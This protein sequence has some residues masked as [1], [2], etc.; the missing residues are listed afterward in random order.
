MICNIAEAAL[1]RDAVCT[2]TAAHTAPG[3]WFLCSLTILTFILDE[4]TPVSILGA[5][6]ELSDR[7]LLAVVGASGADGIVLLPTGSLVDGVICGIFHKLYL[8]FYYI[9]HSGEAAYPKRNASAFLTS[10]T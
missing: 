7:G 4:S 5:T 6:F 1:H 10:V 9:L 8:D 3:G 2:A